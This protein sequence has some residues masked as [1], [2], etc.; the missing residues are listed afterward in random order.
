MAAAAAAV[1][2]AEA[3]AA[4]GERFCMEVAGSETRGHGD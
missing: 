4:D 1:G 2:E 3:D